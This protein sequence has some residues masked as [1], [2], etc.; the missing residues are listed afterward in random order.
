MRFASDFTSAFRFWKGFAGLAVPAAM[1]LMV[2][3][4]LAASGQND[5]GLPPEWRAAWDN[6]PLDCRPMQIVHGVAPRFARADGMEQILG[7]QRDPAASEEGMEYFLRRG[8]GGIVCNVAFDHYL[9][10][11]EHWQTLIQAVDVC[12]KLGM[13]VWIYDEKGYPSASAGG[14]VL[15][16]HPELEALVLAFSGT[17][18]SDPAAFFLRPAY[19]HTHAANNYHAKRRYPNLLDDRATRRF[20]EVTHEAYYQR[21]QPH[22]GTTIRA[23]FT[24]EPSLM[25]VDLGPIPEPAGSKVPVDDPIDPN[26]PK[27]PTVPWAYDLADRYAERY[28]QNLEECRKSLFAGD[29]EEDREVRRRYWSL[30]GDLTAERYFGQI[31][32]WT[33]AHRTASSGHNLHEESIMHHVPLYG[34][35]LKAISRMD[36][37]GL[38]ML[39]S[40]PQAV[41]HS[42]WQTAA[43]PLSGALLRG[44]RRVM[45]EVSDFSQK[46]SGAGPAPLAAVLATAAWQAAWGVT[47]FNLYYRPEDRSPE[48]NLQYGLFVGRLNAVLREAVPVRQVGLY[49]PIRDLWAEYRPVAG[50]LRLASQ[51]E[52]AQRLVGSYYRLGQSLQRRQIP[53]VLTDHEFLAAGKVTAEGK[54]RLGGAELSALL[55]PLDAELPPD[56]AKVVAEWQAA[57]G[58]VIQDKP[59]QPI[60]S[61]NVR[62]AVGPDVV[63]E[64]A[65]DALTLGRFS[66]DGREILL[67]VNVGRS[68]W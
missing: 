35:G 26:V 48:D 65:D 6:P 23:F 14:L 68:E 32:R 50:P 15:R 22:F 52:R 59:E 36:I 12:A 16:G 31:Q 58:K 28:H 18:L 25:A 24:D 39:T 54:L 19:E 53:F 4:P 37:P 56:A 42:G 21:L 63:V 20:I 41:M 57:G 1:C 40:D 2:L 17:D 64:P 30:V 67:L 47:E 11:E 51:S 43:M 62:A 34:N 13:Q 29:T 44:N 45:T 7:Q 33:Q 9:E 61:N 38:D 10:S 3:P 49:Y 66:R 46:M 5:A 60:G 8:R 27:L 55:L